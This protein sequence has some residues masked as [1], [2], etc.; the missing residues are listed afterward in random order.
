MT[1]LVHPRLTY[2]PLTY[3]RIFSQLGKLHQS[4][5]SGEAVKTALTELTA[6]RR[7]QVVAEETIML[8]HVHIMKTAGQT[9]CGILRQ[10][11]AGN[12]CDLV[13]PRPA[14]AKDIRWA[15]RFY[16][17]LKSIAGHCVV[18]YGD[19]E[20]AGFR[21][22]YFTFLRDPIERCVSHYQFSVQK[23][24]C[25][26]SFDRWLTRHANFQTKILSS[27]DDAS[28]AIE[29][30][31]KR[32]CFVGLV[33]RFNESLVLLRHWSGNDAFDVRYRS[34]NIATDNRIKKQLLAS[35]GTVARIE[36]LHTAD[37]QLYA[38]ARDIIYARQTA[39]FGPGLDQA[40]EEME[41]SLPGPAVLSLQQFVASAKRNMLYK[42]LTRYRTRVA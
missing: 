20:Q 16:P 22:R 42:P 31:E 30:L 29:L 39:Q 3:S 41:A 15:M 6:C 40:V 13:V 8:T 19:L 23:N 18:P 10:S 28:R 4:G 14:T 36:E 32:I 9:I 34:R 33:E 12:H 2:S 38:H 7:K 27:T 35:P 17:G 25:R 24:H 37:L 5:A 26:Q 1:R 11:F 21:P